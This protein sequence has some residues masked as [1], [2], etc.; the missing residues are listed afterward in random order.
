MARRES[1]SALIL[2]VL[3]IAALVVS[4]QVGF[5]EARPT[6]VQLGRRGWPARSDFPPCPLYLI[7]DDDM[8][9]LDF[10]GTG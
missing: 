2:L 5:A 1:H 8:R 4:S 9:P 7:N 10:M 3:A 6:S